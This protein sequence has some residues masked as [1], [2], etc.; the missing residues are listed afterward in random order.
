M[1][2]ALRAGADAD[3]GIS[4]ASATHLLAIRMKLRLTRPRK[5]QPFGLFC[6]KPADE[7]RSWMSNLGRGGTRT[8]DS[9]IMSLHSDMLTR[10]YLPCVV[11]FCPVSGGRRV[12]PVPPGSVPCQRYRSHG[13]PTSGAA[14][15]DRVP[16]TRRAGWE[17]S[18]R[19]AP[20]RDAQCQSS[21]PSRQLARLVDHG[22]RDHKRCRKSR[23]FRS[24]ARV[25]WSRSRASHPHG[26]W[27]ALRLAG[28]A[29]SNCPHRRGT[30]R[31]GSRE[32]ARST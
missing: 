28:A 11:T 26:G 15:R 29:D 17:G 1:E 23:G 16:P 32:L 27:E 14:V 19:V 12:R 10:V 22:S 18:C 8:R 30:R 7:T 20:R 31:N 24:S 13:P 21:G 6:G 2:R 25:G 3:T 9:R 5:L 4:F